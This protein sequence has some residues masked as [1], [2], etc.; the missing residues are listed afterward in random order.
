MSTAW[1]QYWRPQQLEDERRL[2][3]DGAPFV[4]TAGEQFASVVPG[5]VVYVLGR[6]GSSLLLMGRLIVD[7]VL[8]E[9]A[10]RARFGEGYTATLHL[11]GQG[12]VMRLDRVVSK[13]TATQLRRAS[14][15]PLVDAQGDADGQKLQAVGPLEA[16]SATLLDRV[17]DRD[18]VHVPLTGLPEGSTK[19]RKHRRVERNRALRDAALRVHGQACMVCGFDF[20]QTYGSRG[21]GFAE[22]H[23]LKPLA[24]L[25]GKALLT[26]AVTDVAVLCANCHRM[27]HRGD[28]VNDRENSPIAIVSFPHPRRGG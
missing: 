13:R 9:A 22:V 16:A 25:Q 21:A 2:G 19:E 12:T 24:S 27:V 5:D 28:D 1:L 26:N 23:H 11:V 10:T 3:A 17:L 15:K 4:E 18:D 14:G 6:S 8:D 7:E 20:E